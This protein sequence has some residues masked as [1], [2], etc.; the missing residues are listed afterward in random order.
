MSVN[1]EELRRLADALK[2]Q[3]AELEQQVKRQAER[4]DDAERDRDSWLNQVSNRVDDAVQAYNERDAAI[5]RAEAAEVWRKRADEQEPS[6]YIAFSDC[7]QF[8]RYWS[9]DKEHLMATLAVNDFPFVEYYALPKPAPA[10]VPEE[11]REVLIGLVAIAE[12]KGKRQ[13]SPNHCH[14]RPG[15]WDD[16]NGVLAGK[17]CAECAVYDKARALLN[18]A[19]H[20]HP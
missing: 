1:T 4:A 5:A 7:G 14:A 20:D 13:G 6:L 17:P 15:I 10:T 9:R 3:I 18:G 11:W 16:D 8:I 2:R 12:K 19:S